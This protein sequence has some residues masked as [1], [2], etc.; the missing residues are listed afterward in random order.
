MATSTHDSSHVV[1]LL[2]SHLPVDLN[3]QFS[4]FAVEG[5]RTVGGERLFYCIKFPLLPPL[6]KLVLICNATSVPADAD[7]SI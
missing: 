1:T 7:I 4:F 6:L 2:V 5:N 3:A